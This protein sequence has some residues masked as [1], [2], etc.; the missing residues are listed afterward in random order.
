MSDNDEL[1]ALRKRVKQQRAELR[2]L[3]KVL[4]PYWTAWRRGHS[5]AR[6]TELRG[7]MI[8]A[9]GSA[10]VRA[11]EHPTPT[12]TQPQPQPSKSGLLARLFGR[13]R[14]NV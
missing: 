4:G 7:K 1:R 11:A 13:M 10:A 5:F 3:N 9:F 12:P 2:R 14:H 6:E 8:A